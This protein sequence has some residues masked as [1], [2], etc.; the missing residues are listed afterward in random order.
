MGYRLAHSIASSIDWTSQIQTPATSSF[1]SAKGPS[2]TDRLVPSK[3]IRFPN[4]LR[5]E[6][7]TRR[8]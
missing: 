8:A 7:V 2:V 3:W 6:P 4:L 1:A 5:R